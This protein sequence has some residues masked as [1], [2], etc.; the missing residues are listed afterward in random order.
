M[1]MKGKTK[2]TNPVE[3]FRIQRLL[4][5]SVELEPSRVLKSQ[6]LIRNVISV[7]RI[8]FEV[9]RGHKKQEKL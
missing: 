4:K 8:N 6:S 2:H 1:I 9:E 5:I 3:K 7:W